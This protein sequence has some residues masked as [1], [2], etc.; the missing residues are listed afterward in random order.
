[1]IV[2]AAFLLFKGLL[3]IGGF[4]AVY[5]NYGYSLPKSVVFS[6]Q[7]CGVPEHDYF[8][9]IRSFNS[10]L[11]WTGMTFGLLTIAIWYWCS[12]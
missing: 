12:E 8:N 10:D 2:G 9:L 7:T 6:N 3:E 1:M 5:T 4:N 11:P